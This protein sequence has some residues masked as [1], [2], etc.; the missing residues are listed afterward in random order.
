L[1]KIKHKKSHDI[2]PL[3][4][5]RKILEQHNPK[6]FFSTA[7]IAYWNSFSCCQ[8]IFQSLKDDYAD[9]LVTK[10]CGLFHMSAIANKPILQLVILWALQFLSSAMFATVV[11]PFLSFRG[12]I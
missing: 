9:F 5:M 10:I 8:F 6:Q 2:V 12:Q 7:C 4:E 3:K 11:N 1:K